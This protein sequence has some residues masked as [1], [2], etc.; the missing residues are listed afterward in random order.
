MNAQ[1]ETNPEML[2]VLKTRLWDSVEYLLDE[3]SIQFYIEG[4]LEE[5]PDDV[6]FMAVVLENVA[7]P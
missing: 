4:A 5:A 7:R 2:P 3:E 6:P 1:L